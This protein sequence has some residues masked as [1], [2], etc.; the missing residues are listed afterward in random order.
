MVS[1]LSLGALTRNMLLFMTLSLSAQIGTIPFTLFYFGRLSLTALGANLFVIPAI[2]VIVGISIF[3]LVLAVI[4]PFAASIYAAANDVITFITLKF[5]EITGNPDFSFLWIR[6]FSIIDSAIFYLLLIL[7]FCCIETFR[8]WKPK[9]LLT[10]FIF[11]NMLFLPSLDDKQLLRDNELNLV[12]I[13]VGQGDAFLLK[14]PN[15]KTALIDAGEKTLGFDNGDRVV[16]PLLNHLAISKIDYAFISHLDSDHCGGFKSLIKKGIISC[17]YKPLNKT[18]DPDDMHFELFLGKYNVPVRYFKRE[19]IQIGN[20]NLYIL[21]EPEN[22]AYEPRT[23]NEQSGIIKIVFGKTSWLFTGDAER[24]TEQFLLSENGSFL[25]SNVLKISHHGS[26]TSSSREFIAAVAP[27][28]AL[29]SS[30]IGNKFNHPSLQV[31]QRLNES[32][33]RIFRTDRKGGV[34][35]VSDGEKINEINWKDL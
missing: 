17:I 21:N 12:M 5:I 23:K 14:F 26:N 1:K 11:T 29:I 15:G 9:L 34:L 2:G 22:S 28:I 7:F 10:G 4:S 24:N 3:T 16:M 30:G 8:G 18:P 19:R 31:L 33:I 6:N 20:T 25:K 13:D 32:G 27:D 35:L